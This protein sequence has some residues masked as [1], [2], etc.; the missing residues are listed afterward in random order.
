MNEL[1]AVLSEMHKLDPNALGYLEHSLSQIVRR[2]G[3]AEDTPGLWSSEWR[4]SARQLAKGHFREAQA[5]RL[6]NDTEMA[7]LQIHMAGELQ[8]NDVSIQQERA[9][10]DRMALAMLFEQ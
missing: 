10:I 6:A 4:P 8:P 7:R 3:V 5:A 2:W 1:Q 9:K